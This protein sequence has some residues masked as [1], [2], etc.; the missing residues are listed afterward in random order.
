MLLKKKGV[1]AVQLNETEEGDGRMIR[2][3]EECRQLK[4]MMTKLQVDTQSDIETLRVDVTQKLTVVEA[5]ADQTNKL[6]DQTLAAIQQLQQN[7][8]APAQEQSRDMFQH[9][10]QS[11]AA[12]P[13]GQ[14]WA[15][16][17]G[18]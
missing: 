15:T 6:Q 8:S 12:A 17:K 5:K 3:E 13:Y 1:T 11:G 4:G 10:H 7:K 16:Q 14:G 2:L 18:G 9:Q